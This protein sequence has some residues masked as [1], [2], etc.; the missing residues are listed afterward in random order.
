[1]NRLEL[2]TMAK[3]QIKGN[4]GI[5]FVIA[6]II[7]AI[8]GAAGLILRFIPYGIGSLVSTIIITPAFS[9][10]VYMIYLNLANGQKPEAKDA[11]N[12]FHDFWS[13]FK[14]SFL[15]GLFTM[16][17]SLLL[18]VPGIIKAISYSQAMYILAENKGMGACEAITRSKTMM[19]GHKSEYFVLGLSFI[20]WML[21]GSITLGIAYI[22]IT[23][24][25]QATYTNFYN[26]IKPNVE[27]TAAPETPNM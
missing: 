4:I 1:M 22:W 21:L 17:W 26:A 15:T 10:S 6:L 13:A 23:P 20:G 7:A 16:L 24:Y 18:V 25:M 2:K 11:F 5:L 3:Q 12:G 27:P 9:L 8:S 19:H 14:V